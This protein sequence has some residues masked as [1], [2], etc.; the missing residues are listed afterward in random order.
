MGWERQKPFTVEQPVPPASNNWLL[1]GV[2]SVIVAVL[3]FFLHASGRLSILNSVN[4]W[5]FSLSP[6]V[7]WLIIFSVRGYFYGRAL[8]RY[9]FL[10]REAQHAQQQWTAWAERYLAVIAS[11]V[12][13]PEQISAALLQ[14]N[15]RGLTQYRDLARRIDY[16]PSDQPAF[17]TA[18]Q[19]L[20]SGVSE[21]VDAL[22]GELPLQVIILTDEPDTSRQNPHAQFADCWQAIF[23]A[24][25]GPSSLTLTEKYAFSAVDERIRQPDET[26]RL[27]LV[28]QMQGQERYSDGLAALLLTSDDVALKYS[29]GHQTRLLRPMPWDINHFGEELELFIT[30]QTQALRTSGILGDAQKWTEHSAELLNIG[31]THGALWEPGKIQMAE[32]YCGIQ[33]PFSPWL[34]AALAADFVRLNQQ[35]WLT[36]STSETEHFICTITSGSGDEPAK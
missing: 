22:P 33:G 36:L 31:N 26:V 23:P 17:V 11:C 28:I 34:A 7:L 9:Q 15:A 14:Q 12:M 29:I 10:Q 19:T 21:T 4:I 1:G 16:L 8:E 18:I 3:L 24:R 6:V 30:T 2:L 35:S 32:T 5:L 13:L 27:I 25:P 20:L